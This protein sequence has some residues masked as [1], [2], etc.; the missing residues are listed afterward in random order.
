M[1]EPPFFTAFVRFLLYKFESCHSDAV[2]T[3][4]SGKRDPLFFILM[5][6]IPYHIIKFLKAK[7]EKKKTER[8]SNLLAEGLIYIADD[9]DET[10]DCLIALRSM[11]LL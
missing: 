7:E 8:K 9:F 2:F 5:V 10:P 6:G 4:I 11:I 3:G 1:P